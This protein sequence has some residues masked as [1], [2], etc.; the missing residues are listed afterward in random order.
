MT[1]YIDSDY[2]CYAENAA[3]LT[4]VESDFFDGKCKSFIEGY[5]FVPMGAT[6]T[7]EDGTVFHGE[8]VSPWKPYAELAA[9]Q[10]GYEES[11]AEMQDMQNALELLGVEPTEVENG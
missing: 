1:V 10:R 7:R 4:A 3:S 2:K 6:W 8:M 11:L 9:A 5:R